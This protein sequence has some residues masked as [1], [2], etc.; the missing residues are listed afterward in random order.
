MAISPNGTDSMDNEFCGKLSGSSDNGFADFAA[1]LFIPD[2][3]TFFQYCRSSG[4]VNRTIYATPAKQRGVCS[5]DN[6]IDSYFRNIAFQY[7]NH[8]EPPLQDIR[9]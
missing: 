2:L 8:N 7:L 3:L 5:V 4:P 6:S 9:L 1:T